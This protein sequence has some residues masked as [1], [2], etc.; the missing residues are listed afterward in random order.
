MSFLLILIVFEKL[1]AMSLFIFAYSDWKVFIFHLKKCN[2]RQK[3]FRD[4]ARPVT[5]LVRVSSDKDGIFKWFALKF[6]K[7]SKTTGEIL[8][9]WWL[10]EGEL[11][12]QFAMHW[13]IYASLSKIE[14]KVEKF[15]DKVRAKASPRAICIFRAL[16]SPF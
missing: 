7:E 1:N 10:W 8:P 16:F 6:A 13:N 15:V 5:S 4:R 11:Q 3:G 9:C 2:F 14:R 12:K